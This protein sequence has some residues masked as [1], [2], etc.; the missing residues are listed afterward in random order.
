MLLRCYSSDFY[1]F[2]I[3]YAFF[4]LFI[5]RP[6]T[7]TLFPY[8]TLFRSDDVGEQDSALRKVDPGGNDG[9]GARD[10]QA[11][12]GYRPPDADAEEHRGDVQRE[13]GG[14][15]AT[16]RRLTSGWFHDSG[17]RVS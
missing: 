12:Q 8:T 9:R 14:R 6:P 13:D 16:L 1:R 11:G 5:R 10:L 2:Y 17:V 7:S 15:S 4:F 3:S